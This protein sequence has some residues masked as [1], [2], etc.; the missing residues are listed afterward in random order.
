MGGD[1]PNP[2]IAEQA[3]NDLLTTH[4][5]PLIE[6]LE[7]DAGIGPMVGL[8][9]NA[10]M[11]KNSGNSNYLITESN[12]GRFGDPEAQYVLSRL[13]SDL[14]K[15]LLAAVQGRLHEMPPLE[16][17]PRPSATLVFATPGYP[18]SEYKKHTGKPLRGLDIIGQDPNMQVFFAGVKKEG[19]HLVNDGG[20]VYAVTMLADTREKAWEEL[21]GIVD[22][23][24]AIGIGDGPEHVHFRKD[25]LEPEF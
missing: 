2:Y 5:I 14:A 12:N 24:K 25:L 18:T 21:Y 7:S 20:R 6:I 1:S 10:L 11:G 19:S 17:D 15:H 16:W 9:Y 3:F 13:K 23:G 22:G 4:T 8:D